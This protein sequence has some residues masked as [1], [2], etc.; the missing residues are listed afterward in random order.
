MGTIGEQHHR[1][2]RTPLA[3]ADPAHAGAAAPM[4]KVH[5][6]AQIKTLG[7]LNSCR[8]NLSAGGH[9]THGRIMRIEM[10]ASRRRKQD[11]HARADAAG[12]NY[13]TALR[14]EPVRSLAYQQDPDTAERD[15]LGQLREL[16]PAAYAE[17]Q[18]LPPAPAGPGLD[19]AVVIH[20]YPT[21]GDGLVVLED[22]AGRELGP[23]THYPLHAVPG[24]LT[25]GYGGAGPADLA[26]SILIAVLGEDARCRTCAGTA[27]VLARLEGNRF[28]Y[29]PYDR[30]RIGTGIAQYCPECEAGIKLLGADYQAFKWARVAGWPGEREFR[31]SVAEVHEWMERVSSP[32]RLLEQAVYTAE[33][34]RPGWYVPR[35]TP[36]PV[37]VL[38]LLLDPHSDHRPRQAWRILLR[39]LYDTRDQMNAEQAAKESTDV[40]AGTYTNAAGASEAAA[41]LATAVEN[42]RIRYVQLATHALAAAAGETDPDMLPEQHPMGEPGFSEPA[43]RIPAALLRRYQLTKI[44]AALPRSGQTGRDLQN[45]YRQEFSPAAARRDGWHGPGIDPQRAAEADALGDAIT[46]AWVEE[47]DEQVAWADAV[48]GALGGELRELLALPRIEMAADDPHEPY[49]PDDDDDQVDDDA[50]AEYEE[51]PS[52]E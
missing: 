33:E 2:E 17:P 39:A 32:D 31:I 3:G 28:V 4:A 9:G 20:G 18:Q 14:A 8:P 42:T 45:A 21:T 40:L 52:V 16:W 26:R 43:P 30:S 38:G 13:T 6:I 10:T 35:E 51:W 25:W 37:V 27:H 23:L 11:A 7:L 49:D 15:M 5:R 50:D 36:M 22:E 46:Q 1:A 34:R 41:L 24:S 47:A 29:E 44:R 48:C 12:T 19:S